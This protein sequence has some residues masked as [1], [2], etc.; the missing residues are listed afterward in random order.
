M[1][2][3]H[4]IADIERDPYSGGRW[5]VTCKCGWIS[6]GWRQQSNATGEHDAHVRLEAEDELVKP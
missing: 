5:I 6:A 3:D 4:A 2:W 1:N